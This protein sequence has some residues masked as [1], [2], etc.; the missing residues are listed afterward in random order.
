M[1]AQI[2]RL[3]T[4]QQSSVPSQLASWWK[5]WGIMVRKVSSGTSSVDG[6]SM[7]IEQQYERIASSLGEIAC[8]V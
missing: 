7:E 4:L 1:L 6:V 2:A 8:S 5:S 3:K